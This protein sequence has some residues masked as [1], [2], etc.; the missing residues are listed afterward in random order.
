MFSILVTNIGFK[1]S[2]IYDD[3]HRQIIVLL[4]L[5]HRHHLEIQ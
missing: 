3:V 1:T 4:I 2:V 5:N